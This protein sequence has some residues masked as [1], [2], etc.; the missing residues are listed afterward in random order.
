M[1]KDQ[2][3]IL[4][5]DGVN[6]YEQWKIEA[7]AALKERRLW[8]YVKDNTYYLGTFGNITIQD[9]KDKKGD[10]ED[11]AQDTGGILSMEH[12]RLMIS[13]EAQDIQDDLDAAMGFLIRSCK[14]SQQILIKD[15]NTPYEA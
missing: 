13:K 12:S 4:K 5:L 9:T 15:C 10:D 7:S 2:G 8:K 6:N 3:N 11:A 14:P 1:S